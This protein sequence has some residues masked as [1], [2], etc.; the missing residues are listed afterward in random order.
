[1]ENLLARLRHMGVLFLIGFLLII[2]IAF[3]ALYLQ[4]G[5]QQRELN[6]QTSKL[7]LILARP[8]PS[9]EEL[10]AECDNVTSLL[11]MT[12][13]EVSDDKAMDTKAIEL[14]VGIAEGSGIDIDESVSKFSVPKVTFSQAKVG[15]GSYQLLSF[16]GIRVQGDYDN[17]MAFIS[18][19]DSGETLKTMVLRT[20]ATSQIEVQCTGEEGDRRVEF[21][22]VLSK[23]MEMMEMM[24][25][26]GLSEIPNPMNFAG[27]IATNLM[28][29]DPDTA[30]D[31][32]GFPDITTTAA[33]KGYTGTGSP[34]DGYV[35]YEH[36]LI[37][38]DNTDNFT[39]VSYI[40]TLTTKY[41][42]T[43][44]AD[45]TERQFDGAD[46]VTATEYVSSGESKIEIVA[47]LSVDIYT[48]PEE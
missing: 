9:A 29:D 23:V 43:C 10:Q 6:D 4:Q 5:T 27:D 2:Y 40:T 20:V 13:I 3:G 31:V 8:L 48:K 16:S 25:D 22:N 12:D 39:T 44:E 33:D 24:E 35:L 46:V 38:P 7:S 11:A 42:Y 19:L 18:D 1:M 45:G 41:Y 14:L 26:N 36:D 28:G 34:R 15:G 47:T 37:D 32:E 21:R 30:V 17:V